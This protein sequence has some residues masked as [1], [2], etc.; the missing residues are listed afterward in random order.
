MRILHLEDSEN[1]AILVEALVR[2]EWPDCRF[3]RV[4]KGAKFREA[5]QRA[6]FD[7]ILSDYSLPDF[8][9]LAAL[10]LARLLCPEKPFIYM[11][12]TIG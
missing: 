4:L 7:L 9:G 1:D 10:E 6:D 3:S 5:L 2:A 11:S 8:D 12:G